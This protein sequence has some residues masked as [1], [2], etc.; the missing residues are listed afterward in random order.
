MA[1][2]ASRGPSSA[3]TPASCTAGGVQETELTISRVMGSTSGS[4][5]AA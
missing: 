5:T 4:G 3:A 2:T 1:S